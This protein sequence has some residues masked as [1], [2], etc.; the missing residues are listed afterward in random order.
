MTNA[1][2]GI[3]SVTG[4]FVLDKARF[5]RACISKGIWAFK[6]TSNSEVK[7]NEIHVAVY[8]YP[9]ERMHDIGSWA[10]DLA[11]DEG[12]IWREGGELRVNEEPVIL[13]PVS[14]NLSPVDAPRFGF[15]L[16]WR[17]IEKVTDWI[18][19]H[20]EVLEVGGSIRRGKP[21]PKDVELIAIAKDTLWLTLD[22]MLAEGRFKK[23]DYGGSTRWGQT[24][25]GLEV[26][27]MKVE[28][29]TASPDTWGY[30]YWL[31]TG[32]GAANQYAVT[33]LWESSMRAQ[34]GAIWY[35]TDW[36][37]I[38]KP[39]K[40]DKDK[41]EWR[42][43]TKRQVS[44]KTEHDMF[45]LLNMPFL[46][47]ADRTEQAYRKALGGKGRTWGNPLPFLMDAPVAAVTA[48]ARLF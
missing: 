1:Y 11:D 19:D 36:E 21:D 46:D 17:V 29:W 45:G 13:P 40:G 38:R 24:Y 42:S 20:C 3:S 16:H 23:A 7:D 6:I 25:R 27:G 41:I 37:E 14:A 5:E 4:W 47:P 32:P 30:I 2:L 34:G 9:T 48:Q 33:R 22:K 31:R 35:A 10:L 26:D 15:P 43:S 12:L 39:V 44:V 8:G 18:A 28:V